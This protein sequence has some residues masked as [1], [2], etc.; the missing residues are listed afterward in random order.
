M[1]AVNCNYI[2]GFSEFCVYLASSMKTRDLLRLYNDNLMESKPSRDQE[3]KIIDFSSL[4]W[5]KVKT[6][7]HFNVL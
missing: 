5:I 6:I 1:K 3:L 7:I 2:D 4:K